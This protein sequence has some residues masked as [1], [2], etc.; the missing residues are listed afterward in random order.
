MEISGF[1][2]KTTPWLAGKFQPFEVIKMY[3]SLTKKCCF[4]IVNVRFQRGYP[5][6]NLKLKKKTE[7]Y[8]ETFPQFGKVGWSPINHHDQSLSHRSPRS[9]EIRPTSKP[10]LNG[11]KVPCHQRSSWSPVNRCLRS[12]FFSC[13][14]YQPWWGGTPRCSK[15]VCF[16]QDLVL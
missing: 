1:P 12:P 4:P 16:H 6:H 2:G 7:K 14:C 15:L 10:H 9:D 8:R 3:F 5:L 11:S 13:L